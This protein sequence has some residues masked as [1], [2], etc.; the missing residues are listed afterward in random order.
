MEHN[1]RQIFE[2]VTSKV[3]VK[4]VALPVSKKDLSPVFS[5]QSLDLHYNTLYQK[6]I[7][8]SHEGAGAFFRA[9]AQLHS[10]F[11]EQLQSVNNQ[12][13]PSGNIAALIDSKFDSFVKFKEKF[14]SNALDFRGSGWIYLSDSGSL[15]TIENHEI[16][17]DILLL[18]DLWEHAYLTDYGADKEKYLKNF[19]KIVNWSTINLRIKNV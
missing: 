19:F 4:K 18:C 10:V 9:G 14:I 6:Y 1:F 12:N 5:E 15:K 3:D 16:R 17:T 11:F 2:Q 8:K 13:R 7:D